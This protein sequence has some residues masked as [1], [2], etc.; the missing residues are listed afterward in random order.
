MPDL[1][2]TCW[3]H[4][5]IRGCAVIG[6]KY[7]TP[8]DYGVHSQGA[9]KV[10]GEFLGALAA[11]RLAMPSAVDLNRSRPNAL[12]KSRQLAQCLHNNLDYY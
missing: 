10:F 8:K 3:K 9:D 6:Y 11:C 12:P 7:H 2:P 1:V 5:L 4:F